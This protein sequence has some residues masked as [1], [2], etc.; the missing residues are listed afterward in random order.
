[1]KEGAI[2]ILFLVVIHRLL[3]AKFGWRKTAQKTQELW[4][5]RDKLSQLQ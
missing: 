4:G 1:V 5:R 2:F 3:K